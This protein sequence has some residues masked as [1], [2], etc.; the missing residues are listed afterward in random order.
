MRQKK[1][2]SVL[3]IVAAN[4]YGARAMALLLFCLPF[5]QIPISK[6]AALGAPHWLY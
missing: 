5:R 6:Q 4:S 3:V 1:E 2:Y